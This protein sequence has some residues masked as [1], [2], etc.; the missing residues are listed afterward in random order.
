MKS[1]LK[2]TYIHN[3]LFLVIILLGSNVARINRVRRFLKQRLDRAAVEILLNHHPGY[4]LTVIF[5]A[6]HCICGDLYYNIF[7]CNLRW[8]N[9]C[10]QTSRVTGGETMM[11]NCGISLRVHFP[12]R[13]CLYFLDLQIYYYAI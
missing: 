13:F 8:I 2:K 7:R 11:V 12:G 9:C 3:Y 10:R 1:E 6:I 4:Q 5:V